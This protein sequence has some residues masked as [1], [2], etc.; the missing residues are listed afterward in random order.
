[1][2]ELKTFWGLVRELSTGHGLDQEDAED[3]A[4]AVVV[5]VSGERSTK[6]LT[7]LQWRQVLERLREKVESRP[8]KS[9]SQPPARD[10]DDLPTAEQLSKIDRHRKA[11]GWTP[12]QLARWSREHASVRK[13]WPQTRREANA[14]IEALKSMTTRKL[15]LRGASR[16]LQV[17]RARAAYLPLTAWEHAFL[18]KCQDRRL[19]A[20]QKIKVEEIYRNRIGGTSETEQLAVADG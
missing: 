17:L 3:I 11:M 7:T 18:A 20:L 14:L 6:S 8:G 19:T 16:H 2:R 10:A 5:E 12:A 1:M 15:D 4:R 13:P 9:A